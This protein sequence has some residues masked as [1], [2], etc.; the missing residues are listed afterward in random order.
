MSCFVGAAVANEHRSCVSRWM[1]SPA[2]HAVRWLLLGLI[3]ATAMAPSARAAGPVVNIPF[4]V[5]TDQ[6]FNESRNDGRQREQG[7]WELVGGRLGAATLDLTFKIDPPRVGLPVQPG[8][9]VLYAALHLFGDAGGDVATGGWADSFVAVTVAPCAEAACQDIANIALPLRDLAPAITRL[10]TNG[11]LMWVSAELTLVRSFGGGTWLQV[12]PFMG[13]DGP[14]DAGAGRLGSIK[15][16]AGKIFPYGLFPS[17]EATS[18]PADAELL[19]TG[20]Q[21]GADVE[22]RRRDAGDSSMPLTTALGFLRATINPPCQGSFVLTVH[23]EGGDRILDLPLDGV[24]TIDKGLT[25]PVG[26]PWWLTLQDGGGIDFDQGRQGTGVRLGPIGTD[27]TPIAID[28]AFDCSVPRG[29]VRV[30]GAIV[31]PT[32]APTRAGVDN[33]PGAGTSRGESAGPAVVVI[34]AFAAVVVVLLVGSRARKRS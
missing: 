30:D 22:Q 24:R 18:I 19:P 10:E 4:G 17:S 23:D 21:Y 14:L 33:G 9:A 6:L 12:L 16:A 25:I 1:T 5:A 15:P 13:A 27:E 32:E 28:A 31:A 20:F 34:A 8:P 29:V 3:A 7:R 11:S 2:S 26:V